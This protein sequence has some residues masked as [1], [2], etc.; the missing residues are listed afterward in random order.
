MPSSLRCWRH[1]GRRCG[2]AAAAEMDSADRLAAPV[3]VRG[4][5]GS[6]PCQT[7]AGS[8]AE[9]R[10]PA[11]PFSD[12]GMRERERE[13]EQEKEAVTLLRHHHPSHTVASPPSVRASQKLQPRVAVST[14]IRLSEEKDQVSRESSS[15]ALS[16]AQG[17]HTRHMTQ[18]PI[19]GNDGASAWRKVRRCC[20][21]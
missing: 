19:K 15:N 8:P 20:R 10:L 9:L 13:T 14:G 21:E 4:V 3:H 7:C 16:E 1:S 6:Q 2:D 12:C 17:M 11:S 5:R 18:F